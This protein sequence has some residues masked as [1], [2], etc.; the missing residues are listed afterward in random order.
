MTRGE[1]AT[2][3]MLIPSYGVP[4]VGRVH[5]RAGASLFERQP[6]ILVTG[7]WLTVKEQMADLYAAALAAVASRGDLRLRRVGA[8]RR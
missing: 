3:D 7:S 2:F 1:V 4:L 6:T 8:E 5:R